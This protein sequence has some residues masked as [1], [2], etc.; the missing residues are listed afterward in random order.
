MTT[1]PMH[2]EYAIMSENAYQKARRRKGVVDGVG[3]VKQAATGKNQ[4]LN[5]VDE[6]TNDRAPLPLKGWTPL[7]FVSTETDREASDLGL[8]MEA[9]TK[10]ALD[11]T[12]VVVF[13]GTNFWET[14]DW[15]ANFRWFLR[16]IPGFKDQYT[17]LAERASFDLLARLGAPTSEY[18]V[19]K[20]GGVQTADGRPV[21]LIA[22]GHSLGGGLAQHFAYSFRQPPETKAGLKV[23]E[24]FA[25]DTTPVTGWYSAKD[26][27]RTYNAKNLR[28]NR[29]F[30]HGEALAYVRL[31]TSR[32][33]SSK[34]NPAIW[35]YR[36]DFTHRSSFVT[37]HHMRKLACGLWKAAQPK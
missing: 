23:S 20:E 34:E 9:W 31:F 22:T 26:P 29:I 14:R 3:G 13:E 12:I 10:D 19:N 15:R 32:L 8:Y 28:I 7:D 6:C 2:W 27:P 18:R 11:H 4:T 35:E 24:V 33:S 37:N 1:A 30:E 5:A 17:I 25:F 21:K 36:Y 16:F